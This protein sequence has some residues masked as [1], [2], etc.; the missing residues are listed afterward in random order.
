MKWVECVCAPKTKTQGHINHLVDQN[1]SREWRGDKKRVSY[2]KIASMWR[3]VRQVRSLLYN[4]LPN[5]T[6]KNVISECAWPT[7]TR[8]S[9]TRWVV[10]G[11]RDTALSHGLSC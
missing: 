7:A 2:A 10:S 6:A 5:F 1:E 4:S 11:G 9:F 8:R 3:T